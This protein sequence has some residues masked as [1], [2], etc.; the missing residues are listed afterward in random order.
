[1]TSVA[2]L[3]SMVVA[4]IAALVC[5]GS[6]AATAPLPEP[7]A[8]PEG[9]TLTPNSAAPGERIDI[10]AFCPQDTA[11]ATSPV[12][13]PATL[14]PASDGGLVANTEVKSQASADVYT[15]TIRCDADVFHVPFIVHPHPAEHAKN[16]MATVVTALVLL[17]AFA[18]LAFWGMRFYRI[19]PRALPQPAGERTPQARD[20]E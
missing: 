1:M 10:R 8:T 4:L 9:I 14:S 19:T 18:V 3:V 2:R 5:V 17:L 13:G 16:T 7:L 15:M 11:L 20:A 6:A 12:T